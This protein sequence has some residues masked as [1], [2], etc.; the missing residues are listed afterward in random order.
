MKKVLVIGCP[1]S[2][3]STLSR[4]LHQK[5]GLPLYH[6]DQLFWNADKTTVD[7]EVFMERLRQVLQQEE[8][9]LD[10]NYSSTLELRLQHCDTVIFLDY[11]TR[12]CLDGVAARRGI[13][14]SDI[15]WV[16]T[17][18]DPE[19]TAFIQDFNTKSRP[20]LLA[21]LAQYPHKTLHVFTHRSQ[22]ERFLS[23]IE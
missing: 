2:G 11:P 22:A 4:A 9:I 18:E 7:K 13:P 5:T 15:P 12:L 14:R 21:L 16:E 17:Q 20:E 1:G 3:K 19:F 8:W 23:R 10:G 6:L